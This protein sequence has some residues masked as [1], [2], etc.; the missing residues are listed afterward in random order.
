MGND[1]RPKPANRVVAIEE[2]FIHPSIWRCFPQDLQRRYAPVLAR[3]SDVGPRRIARMDAVGVDMQVLSHV[4]PGVQIIGDDQVDTAI[5]A[6]RE[7]ND[8]LGEVVETYPRRFAG[9]AALPTQSPQDAAR[10][11]ERTVKTFG[12]KGALINGHT[13]GRYLDDPS[14]EPLLAKAEALKVPIY[15]HPTDPPKA[16]GDVYYQPYADTLSPAWGWSVETGTHLLRMM[17]GGVFDRHP[18]LKIIVGHMGELL[19]Y[20]YTRL[21]IGLTMGGWIVGKGQA[22]APRMTSTFSDYMR[23]NVYVTSS[24]VFDQPVFACAVAMLGLDNLIFSI[25]SP[26]RDDV[27]AMEF[28]SNCGLSA[29]DKERFAHETAARLLG[30]PPYGRPRRSLGIAVQGWAARLKS[31]L[32]RMLVGAL[33][34]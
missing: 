34:N 9:F 33:V 19:P 18:D 7:A 14:F 13:N 12:F 27:E 4:Q 3:L 32:G 2:A 6:S 11:L 29:A 17:C 24:G 21:N 8:W 28:L 1:M 26:M 5:A 22:Q 20:C 15:I 25:D 31:R 23:R 10:E 30:L 16:V